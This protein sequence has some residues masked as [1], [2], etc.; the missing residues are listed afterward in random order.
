AASGIP[1]PAAA[2]LLLAHLQHVSEP[3]ERMVHYLRHVARYAPA[4]ETEPLAAL[5]QRSVPAD[6]DL[7]LDLHEVA[8]AG[9][10]ERGEAMPASMRGWSESLVAHYLDRAY[11]AG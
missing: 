8:R 5:V 3:S 10:A 6:L 2:R 9:I 7:Q 1:T 11:G 4:A